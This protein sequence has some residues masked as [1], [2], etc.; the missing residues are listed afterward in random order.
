MPPHPN[1]QVMAELC[2]HAEVACFVL[3]ISFSMREN[4]NGDSI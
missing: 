4:E 1:H 2:V 3:E